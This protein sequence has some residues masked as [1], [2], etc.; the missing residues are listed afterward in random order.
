VSPAIRFESDGIELSGDLRTEGGTGNLGGLVLHPHPLYGGD[1]R[2][3]V[4]VAVA[5]ALTE[6]AIPSLAFDFRGAGESGGTHGGGVPEIDDVLAAAAAIKKN[7]KGVTSI[8]L[9]GYSYGAYVASLAARTLN[10]VCIA[11]IAPPQGMLP[12]DAL[13]GFKGPILLAAG[14]NDQFA[15]IDSVRELARRTGARLEVLKNADHFLWGREEE[16]AR[17]VAEFAKGFIE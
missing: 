3:G 2:N 14:D 17:I 5:G 1:R 8:A 7:V 11:C 9:V 6:A 15:P 16:A 13:N 10:P 12:C 4:V